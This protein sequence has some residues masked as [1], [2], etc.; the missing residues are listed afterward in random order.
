MSIQIK[1]ALL[2]YLFDLADT[3]SKEYRDPRRWLNRLIEYCKYLLSGSKAID[4]SIDMNNS[5][6]EL[7]ELETHIQAVI[8]KS[9]GDISLV[10]ECLNHF[11][12]A[13][14]RYSLVGREYCI[15]VLKDAK[16]RLNDPSFD[17][18][19]P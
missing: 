8:E 6:N 18:H 16:I 3:K 7:E 17:R 15:E 14:S 13:E 19:N 9:E 5:S 10:D 1:S 11:Q 12:T 4:F 2:D